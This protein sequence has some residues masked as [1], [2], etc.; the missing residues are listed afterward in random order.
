MLW[1]RVLKKECPAALRHG[2]D[3]GDCGEMR[4]LPPHHA[5]R[6]VCRSIQT[7]AADAISPIE[8][9][10]MAFWLLERS[11]GSYSELVRSLFPNATMLHFYRHAVERPVKRRCKRDHES[12]LDT[13]CN[14]LLAGACPV[15]HAGSGLLPNSSALR[16]HL[17]RNGPNPTILRPGQ[18]PSAPACKNV[19]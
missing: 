14:R 8:W 10:K 1:T 11:E 3:E 17:R 7:I 16:L 6:G 18:K 9:Q 15:L 12:F 13:R 5:D 2:R 19:V 4:A